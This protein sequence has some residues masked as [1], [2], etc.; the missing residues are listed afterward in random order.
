MKDLKLTYLIL[1]H[2]NP[3]QLVRLIKRLDLGNRTNFVIHLDKKVSKDIFFKVIDRPNLYFIPDSERVEVKWGGLSMISALI[4]SMS[5]IQRELLS[6]YVILLSNNDYPIKTAEYIY[7]FVCLNKELNFI[8]G[9]LFPNT[10]WA[11]GGMPRIKGFSF[12]LSNRRIAT[13][14]PYRIGIYN[15]R[16]FVKVLIYRPS[17]IFVVI[18]AFFRKRELPLNVILHGGEFWW[19]LPIKT[20]DMILDFC[21]KNRDY[22]SYHENTANPDEIFINSIVHTFCDSS[23]ISNHSLRY[24]NWKYD[25]TDVRS[26]RILTIKDMELVQSCILNENYL[27]IRKVD[28][29]VDCDILEYIDSQI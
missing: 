17:F 18:A 2:N 1:V 7:E 16:Q 12:S 4:N 19:G 13:I 22:F 21:Y 5:F 11:E 20:I 9:E 24:I 14:L 6:D 8:E 26:P 15:L 27:F 23:S 25:I 3:D 28:V 29:F 10:F